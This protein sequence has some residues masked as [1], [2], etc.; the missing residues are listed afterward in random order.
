T[1][2]KLIQ[3]DRSLFSNTFAN[4]D[5][6]LSSITQALLSSA[7]VCILRSSGS[8]YNYWWD[9]ELKDLKQKSIDAHQV[10][11]SHGKPA[12]GFV[13]NL[14][15]NA[16]LNYKLAIRLKEKNNSSSISNELNEFLA[17]KDTT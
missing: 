5:N 12:H 10:W 1:I 14:K 13:W 11:A 16:K 2:N 8:F 7:D 17:A 15:N 6:L 3:I 4:I 9:D